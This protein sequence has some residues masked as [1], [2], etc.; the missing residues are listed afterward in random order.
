M[1]V[2]AI[3]DFNISISTATITGLILITFPTSYD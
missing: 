1:G 2:P 3:Y